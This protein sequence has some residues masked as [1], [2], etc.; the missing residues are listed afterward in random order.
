MELMRLHGS[1]D[2]HLK[3]LVSALADTYILTFNLLQAL[4]A[5]VFF[6]RQ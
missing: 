3:L 4:L 6:Y 5:L 2:T 1:K